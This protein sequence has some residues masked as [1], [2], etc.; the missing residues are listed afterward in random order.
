MHMIQMLLFDQIKI[1]M[2]ILINIILDSSINIPT[3]S[4]LYKPHPGVVGKR[5]DGKKTEEQRQKA[6]YQRQ[7]ISGR[8]MSLSTYEGQKC[9]SKVMFY[10]KN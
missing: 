3:A 8:S 9:Q 2:E 1:L 5:A 7:T 10:R 6:E 4:Y